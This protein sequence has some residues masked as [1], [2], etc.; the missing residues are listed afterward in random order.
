MYDPEAKEKSQ[1][2]HALLVKA[3]LFANGTFLT[4]KPMTSAIKSPE[5]LML[6]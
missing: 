3:F 4:K 1:F 5:K 2:V 6:Y